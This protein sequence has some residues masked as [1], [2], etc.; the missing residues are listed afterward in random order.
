MQT[1]VRQATTEDWRAVRS[2]RLAALQ[3]SPAAF[4]STYDREHAFVR[5]DWLRRLRGPGATFIATRPDRPSD[6]VG[7]AGGF[8]TD[9]T[10]ELVSMWVAPTHRGSGVATDLVT[11]VVEWAR[12]SGSPTIHLWVTENNAAARSLYEHHGFAYTDQSQPLPSD[13]AILELGMV[14]STDSATETS[15]G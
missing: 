3:D 6:P 8:P 13:P 2:V 15:S 1:H 5:E 11:A 10:I 7:I 12:A 9:G 14:R 4:A